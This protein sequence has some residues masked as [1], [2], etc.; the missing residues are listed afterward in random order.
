[1]ASRFASV[2]SKIALALP[3]GSTIDT[4]MFHCRSS[5]RNA[6]VTAS[7]ANFDAL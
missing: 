6:S 7:M 5:S 3:P 2:L 4:W 1:M